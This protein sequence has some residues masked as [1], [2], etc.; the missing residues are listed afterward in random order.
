MTWCVV[1]H[2]IDLYPTILD[3]AGVDHLKAINDKPSQPLHGKSLLPI[4]KGDSRKPHDALYWQ[5]S[6]GK[7]VRH[8]KWKLV[9]H[10]RGDWE[11]YDL[12]A[13]GTE[14]NNLANRHPDKVKELTTMFDQWVT[15]SWA[16]RDKSTKPA[17]RKKP[18]SK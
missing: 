1:A 6:Q 5:W 8:G 17:K 11:L 7:A 9:A 12:D 14:L 3:L 2:V 4:F 13:D 16:T 10:R 15:D 18:K